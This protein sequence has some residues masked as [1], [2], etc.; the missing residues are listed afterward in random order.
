[1]PRRGRRGRSRSRSRK[2]GRQAKKNR[3]RRRK[4]E[5]KRKEKKRKDQKK[6]NSRRRY[7]SSSRSTRIVIPT[8]TQR[9]LIFPWDSSSDS[10]KPQSAEPHDLHNIVGY[11]TITSTVNS[12][13]RIYHEEMSGLVCGIFLIFLVGLLFI[14]GCILTIIYGK[15]QSILFMM[16]LYAGLNFALIFL[17]VAPICYFGRKVSKVRKKL[18]NFFSPVNIE[19][20]KIGLRWVVGVRVKWIELTYLMGRGP[21]VGIIAQGVGANPGIESLK[22]GGNEEQI[23]MGGQQNEG[24]Q[25]NFGMNVN[26]GG[27]FNQGMGMMNNQG[28]FDQG[29]GMMNNQGNFDQGMGMMNNGNFFNQ[30]MDVN[31]GNVNYNALM[32]QRAN[33]NSIYEPNQVNF[34]MDDNMR[35]EEVQGFPNLAKDPNINFRVESQGLPPQEQAKRLNASP[36]GMRNNNENEGNVSFMFQNP[37]LPEQN[38]SENRGLMMVQI[39]NI[40]ADYSE[41]QGQDGNM[42]DNLNTF[43]E[44]GRKV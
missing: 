28:N 20:N 34:Q 5:K 33:M 43:Y 36:F 18:R 42:A 2:R 37:P 32:M 15:E 1:M 35:D 4:R 12:A 21:G 29:M 7:G 38:M 25:N 22:E 16:F 39:N 6:K 10:F 17:I 31:G 8:T 24:I 9:R 14:G 11:Q 19:L 40:E 41:Y 23:V 13:S 30:G 26:R 44:G 3:S 27:N